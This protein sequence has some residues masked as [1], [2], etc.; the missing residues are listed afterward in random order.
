M[1]TVINYRSGYRSI[2]YF[3]G[4][5]SFQLPLLESSKSSSRL[6]LNQSK[7][8]LTPSSPMVDSFPAINNN[9]RGVENQGTTNNNRENNG[10][11]M[12]PTGKLLL[13]IVSPHPTYLRQNTKVSHSQPRI[14]INIF[15]KRLNAGKHVGVS[16]TVLINFPLMHKK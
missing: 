10:F 11:P 16:K 8:N 2:L 4:C 1:F 14:N 9:S 12:T 5:C 6:N 13:L 15:G 3:I 7:T